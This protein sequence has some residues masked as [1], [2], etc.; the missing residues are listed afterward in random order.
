VQDLEHLARHNARADRGRAHPVKWQQAARSA[1][2][3]PS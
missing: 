1:A 3:G 2:F